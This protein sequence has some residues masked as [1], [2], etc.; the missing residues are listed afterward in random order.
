MDVALLT[1][2]D[3]L[4]AGDTQNTNATWLARQLTERGVTVARVLVV[5]DD[6]PLIANTVRDWG[7]QFDAVIVTGGLG[8]THD[9]VTMAAVADAFDTGLTTEEFVVEDVVRTVADYRDRNP[10]LVDRYELDLDID[11]WAAT[12]EGSRPLLNEP[13]LCPGCVLEN[14]YV[15]PGVPEEMRSMFESVAEAFD[16]NAVSEILE[17]DAPEGA[18]PAVLAQARERFDIVLGSYPAQDGPNR[19]KI[20]GTDPEEVRS[21]AAW[22]EKRIPGR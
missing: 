14:V 11:A 12:P 18:M 13:G 16:G 6:R 1:V 19:V 20:T 3:E 10:E 21:A 8:G 5:P 17:T 9:D 4:L 7:A 2:G 22:I 15:F